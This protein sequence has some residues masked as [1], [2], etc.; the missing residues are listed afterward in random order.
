MYR[1][2]GTLLWSASN[3]IVLLPDFF[4]VFL[5]GFLSD[6]GESVCLF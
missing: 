6:A 5:S 1:G 3:F 2:S 4:L